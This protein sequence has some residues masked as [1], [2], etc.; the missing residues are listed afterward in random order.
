[1]TAP[2]K[3][4]NPSS[5]CTTTRRRSTALQRRG[6]G[7]RQFRRRASRPSRRDRC[8]D[9]ARRRARRAG[10]RRDVRAASAQRAAPVRSGVPPD[11]RAIEAAPA[12]DAPALPARWCSPSTRRSPRLTRGGIRHAHPGR[13]ARHPRRDHRVRFSF[14]PSAARLA[15]VPRR[16]GRALHGFSVETAPPLE[17][18]GRPVSSSSIRAALADGRVVEAAELLGY[19]W[20]AAG[21]V[22][23]GR[24]ARARSRISDREYRA[25]SELRPE[26]R[27][28]CG[29]RRRSAA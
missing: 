11:R 8:R 9:R 29:A 23:Q 13:P 18:E 6:R 25:R 12:R 19:P 27:H 10:D 4:A 15:G 20:F 5:S 7:D 14:R 28:L 2:A 21:T 24:P 26:A 3:P 16:T 1:M 17:D 22:V